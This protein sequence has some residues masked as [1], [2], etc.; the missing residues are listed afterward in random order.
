MEYSFDK[1]QLRG[2]QQAIRRNPQTVAR[3][4][5]K[6]LARGIAVYNRG[7]IRS[8]WRVGMSGG[9]APVKTGNLRDTHKKTVTPWSAKITPNASY[10]AA[11]HKNRPWLDYVFD[12]SKQEIEKLQID[13]LEEIT[14]D[15][16]K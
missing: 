7:I 4:V 10:A 8:P 16:A 11:V 3:E 5:G 2:L 12:T 14:K 1:A 13:L 6:F 15:L 9:G